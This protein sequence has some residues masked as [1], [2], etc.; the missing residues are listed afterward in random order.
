MAFT[1]N[2]IIEKIFPFTILSKYPAALNPD[3]TK[4]NVQD[5]PFLLYNPI[6]TRIEAVPSINKNAGPINASGPLDIKKIKEIIDII[7][8]ITPLITVNTMIITI[9]LGIFFTFCFIC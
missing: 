6:E 2:P 9:P 8:K 1:I 4:S 7:N 5:Q 3:N